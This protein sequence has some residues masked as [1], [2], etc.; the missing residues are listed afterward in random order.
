MSRWR[1]GGIAIGMRA[2][3]G[4]EQDRDREST[5]RSDKSGNDVIPSQSGNKSN[6]RSSLFCCSLCSRRSWQ[7]P[8]W[9]RWRE[10]GRGMGKESDARTPGKVQHVRWT[11]GRKSHWGERC[12]SKSPRNDLARGAMP[13]KPSA[14]RPP[15]QPDHM[16][17]ST[18]TT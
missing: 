1:S 11:I 13:A 18:R 2:A 14:V 17:G 15:T 6:V 12:T 4:V 8:R 5:M 16:R 7:K 10:G 9:Q 3:N